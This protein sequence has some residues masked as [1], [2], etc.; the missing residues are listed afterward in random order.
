MSGGSSAGAWHGPVGRR[1]QR[2]GPG[3]PGRRSS[4][5]THCSGTN[6]SVPGPRP[7][8]PLGGVLVRSVLGPAA[9]GARAPS[10]HAPPSLADDRRAGRPGV[11]AA[12]GPFAPDRLSAPWPPVTVPSVSGGPATGLTRAW[13]TVPRCATLLG[14]GGPAP[15]PLPAVVPL[16]PAGL[17]PTG[18][19]ATGL[20]PTGAAGVAVRR[21]RCRSP[22][23]PDPHAGT[24]TTRP[25]TG[26]SAGTS[27]AADQGV[28]T[29]PSDRV[30]RPWSPCLP[31]GR[32]R[33][34]GPR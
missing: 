30:Y 34:C 25:A 14:A 6:S 18:L 9:H 10:G 26:G 31:S 11:R 21:N 17:L 7:P 28:W 13:T 33:R 5:R 22:I 27:R 12:A 32:T 15:P 29:L 8:P 19:L 4:V 2:L 16:L 20:L 23:G 24:R 3:W 1:S